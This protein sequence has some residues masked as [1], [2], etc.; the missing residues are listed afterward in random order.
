[1]DRLL[2][3]IR[4]GLQDR[5]AAAAGRAE[6][7]ARLGR[8]RLDI[9]ALKTRIYRLQAELGTEVYRRRQEGTAEP[10]QGPEVDALC[11]QL[12]TLANELRDRESALEELKAELEAQRQARRNPA[13]PNAPLEVQ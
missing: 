10:T 11:A 1:M 12:G 3:A 8:A 9:A 2:D 7:L 4:K 5:A 13:R 6:E